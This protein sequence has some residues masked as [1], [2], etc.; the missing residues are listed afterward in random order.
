MSPR[1]RKM[2]LGLKREPSVSSES[3]VEGGLNYV[4]NAGGFTMEGE[5]VSP[6]ETPQNPLN[7]NTLPSNNGWP[8]QESHE[9]FYEV[10]DEPIYTPAFEAFPMELQMPPSYLCSLSQPPTPAFGQFQSNLMFNNG[11]PQFEHEQP[12][13]THSNHSNHSNQQHTEYSFPE[14]HSH[15]P[16]GMF[17]SPINQHKTF[18]FSNSTPA[19][20][21]EK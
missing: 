3:P 17:P 6:P 1:D 9:S 19:D 12:M 10:P 4:Y 11:S 21:S 5:M 16:S 15:F 18:Q 2:N 7:L 20:F 8:S 14:S 13:Y